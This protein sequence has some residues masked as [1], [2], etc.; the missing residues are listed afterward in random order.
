MFLDIFENTFFPCIYIQICAEGSKKK[1]VRVLE[2]ILERLVSWIVCYIYVY[3]IHRRFVD[4]KEFIPDA[5][6]GIKEPKAWTGLFT[7]IQSALLLKWHSQLFT[8][9]TIYMHATVLWV[10]KGFCHPAN[11]LGK[12]SEKGW[13]KLGWLLSWITFFFWL[14]FSQK[15]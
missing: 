2:E 9:S 10:Q 5:L 6:G 11:F 7:K 13:R 8:N 4:R 15:K 14:Y 3:N 12:Q 1:I